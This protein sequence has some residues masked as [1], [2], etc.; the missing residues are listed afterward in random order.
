MSWN[1][2]FVPALLAALAALAGCPTTSETPVDDDDTVD[3]HQAQ[4][5]ACDL[6]AEA[7]TPLTA[8]NSLNPDPGAT[9]VFDEG[10]YTVDLVDGDHSFI[11]W[12]AGADDNEVIVFLSAPGVVENFWE[13]DHIHTGGNAEPN[14]DCPD[15]IPEQHYLEL[16]A[17][18][19]Y[20]E[21]GVLQI[22][23]LWVHLGTG[24][25][26]GTE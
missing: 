26:D 11:N 14:P 6:A 7:G 19:W 1:H 18:T 17:G 3:E 2:L 4:L 25:E 21:V 8:V 23:S 13:T 9:M 16:H 24:T 20:M 22:D 12:E 10:P 5:T 15:L